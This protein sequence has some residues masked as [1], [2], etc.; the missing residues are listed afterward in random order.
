MIKFFKQI[1]LSIEQFLTKEWGP[2][3][4]PT[5]VGAS[6]ITL[7]VQGLDAFIGEPINPWVVMIL[8]M[9]LISDYCDVKIEL[10]KMDTKLKEMQSQLVDL[11]SFLKTED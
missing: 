4:I 5:Y 2:L 11:D 1:L 3:K 6:W 7:L 9:F 8:T 10:R